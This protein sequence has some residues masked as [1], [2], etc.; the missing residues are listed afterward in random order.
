MP[1]QINNVTVIDDD[2]N[3]NSP[4]ITTV[5]SGTSI[6]TIDGNN[7]RINVGT[8]VTVD[9][10]NGNISIAGTIIAN[11]FDIPVNVASFSPAN[12]D[13]NVSV[14]TT[15]IVLT[16]DQVVALGSTGELQLRT[17]GL[18]GSIVQT[19]GVG[20][21]S[22]DSTSKIL[23]IG[24]SSLGTLPFVTSYYPILSNHVIKA[25][26][27]QFVGINS[28]APGSPSYY[29]V[30]KAYG[31]GDPG[32]GGFNICESGGTRWIVAPDSVINVRPATAFPDAI[33]AAN[34]EAACGDWFIPTLS[35]LQ[36]PG[37]EC[38]QY[39]QTEPTGLYY[40][41]TNTTDNF[42]QNHGGGCMCLN[43]DNGSTATCFV[44]NT[45]HVAPFRCL[46]Y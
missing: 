41:N 1:I 34:T 15:E 3:F 6:I 29:F 17:G 38:K 4:G 44:S 27:G 13:T 21:M 12:A 24:I 20:D 35:Q 45:A 16:F 37:R 14:S 23:T 5:G 31:L 32:D 33:N 9:G 22:L 19:F 28:D 39:W 11:G 40:S 42:I 2:R 30:T 25:T 46:S 7:S 26:S 8:A 18:L 43:M 10:K 36:N